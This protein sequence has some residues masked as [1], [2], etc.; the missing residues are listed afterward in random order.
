[1]E[2]RRLF[3]LKMGYGLSY[4]AYDFLKKIEAN[5]PFKTTDIIVYFEDGTQL[6]ANYAHWYVD[7]KYIIVIT[8][9]S[10]TFVIP[11]VSVLVIKRARDKDDMPI[12][13]SNASAEEISSVPE[14]DPL[15]VADDDDKDGIDS[16][17]GEL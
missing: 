7:E 13:F 4:E 15:F 2:D 1:M 5:W 3:H 6:N 9:H 8:E 16:E 10:G 11:K 12:I 14:F 17:E